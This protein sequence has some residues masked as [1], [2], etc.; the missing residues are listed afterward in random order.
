MGRPTKGYNSHA[1]AGTGFAVG[2]NTEARGIGVLIGSGI[3]GDV[4]STGGAA[5]IF[6]GEQKICSVQRTTQGTLDISYVF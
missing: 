2:T 3:S 5:I 1:V 6:T 4:G